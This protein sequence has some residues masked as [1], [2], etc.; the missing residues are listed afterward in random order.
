MEKSANKK[1][2]ESGST[3]TFKEWIDRENKK[4]GSSEQGTFIPFDGVPSPDTSSINDTLRQAENDILV[5]NQQVHD[6][7]CILN[8]LMNMPR[9][10]VDL[11]E[12]DAGY[13]MKDLTLKRSDTDKIH[14]PIAYLERT[15]FK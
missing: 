2:K 7:E 11:N 3:L 15:E 12:D 10:V 13:Q 14:E 1:W 5:A 4:N 6:A 8:G 9:T